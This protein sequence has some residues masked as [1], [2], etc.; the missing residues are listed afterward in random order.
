MH[1]IKKDTIIKKGDYLVNQQGEEWEVKDITGTQFL[2]S[3]VQ[4]NKQKKIDKLQLM[5]ENHWQMKIMDK[6]NY[7]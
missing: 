3:N 6:R 4:N 1:N 7:W 5:L 2:I